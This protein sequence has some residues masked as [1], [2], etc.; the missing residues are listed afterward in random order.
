MRAWIGQRFE[1]RGLRRDG[2]EFPIELSVSPVRMLGDRWTFNTVRPRHQRANACA[3]ALQEAEEGFRRAF[4]DN[5]VGMAL[6]SEEGGLHAGQRRL[7][8]AAR[9]SAGGE[10]IGTPFPEI[11]HPDDIE[12]SVTAVREIVA[13]RAIRLPGREAVPALEGPLRVDRNQRLA[14]PR[15]SAANLIHL[16]A[17]IEDITERKEQEA[18][19]THQALH[20]PLTGLP[21]R[22]LFADRVRVASARRDSGSFGVIYIDLDTFKPINDSFGHS[23]G[24]EVLVEVARRLEIRLREGDTLARLGGRRVRGAVRRHR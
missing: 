12:A 3:R 15:R 14:D 21:N 6:L 17:Q 24:D 1:A 8:R 5:R 11:T 23:A 18:R 16:I 10:L 19:L 9:L 22:V 7:L 2:T 4:E 20:D 13:G